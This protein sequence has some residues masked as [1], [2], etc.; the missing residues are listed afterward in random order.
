MDPVLRMQP[1]ENGHM[2]VTLDHKKHRRGHPH[3]ATVEKRLRDSFRRSY[4]AAADE[5][6]QL[7]QDAWSVY[8]Q[9]RAVTIFVLTRLLFPILQFSDF[10]R[11]TRYLVTVGWQVRREARLRCW[12]VPG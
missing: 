1:T 12:F 5:A 11:I 10:L 8:Q 2:V 3:L 9:I 7:R 4:K 6:E